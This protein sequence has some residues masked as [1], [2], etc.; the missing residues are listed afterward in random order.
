[1]IVEKGEKLLEVK[2]RMN[3]DKSFMLAFI[4]HPF[5]DRDCNNSTQLARWKK[6]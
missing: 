4:I 5:P 1:M 2:T 6:Y 3:E